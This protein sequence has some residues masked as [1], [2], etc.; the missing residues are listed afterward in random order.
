[1]DDSKIIELYQNRD[2]SAITKTAQKYGRYL[3]KI[4][5]NILSDL[6]D[7][8]ECV[9]DTYLRTWNSIPPQKPNVLSAFL[10]RITRYVSL[11]LLRKKYAGIRGNGEYA[12]SLDELSEVVSGSDGGDDLAIQREL[13]GAIDSFLHSLSVTACDIFVMRYFYADSIKEIARFYGYSE[14]KIK[15]SLFRTRQSLA[16]FLKKEGYDI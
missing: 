11:D 3:T 1:M 5:Y 4:S 6:S 2:Q 16:E 10:A 15:T 12:L 14:A 13:I 9:N 8:E 7:A